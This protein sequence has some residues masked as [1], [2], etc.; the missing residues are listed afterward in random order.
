MRVLVIVRPDA[1]TRFG[2]DTVLARENF[3]ALKDIGVDADFVETDRP[4]PRGYD[5]A[6]IFNVGQPDVCKRQ[7]DACYAA[8][9]PVALSP[10][11]LDL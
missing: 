2:G 1:S 11:W 10:V 8:D 6:H 7:M 4:E 5:I 3:A 9:V